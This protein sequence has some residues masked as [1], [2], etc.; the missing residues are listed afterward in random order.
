MI[1]LLETE[2]EIA[3]INNYQ[4]MHLVVLC[5]FQD[6]C[7]SRKD[8]PKSPQK[9]LVLEK[10]LTHDCYHITAFDQSNCK[11]AGPALILIEHHLIK[12]IIA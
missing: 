6:L 9:V 7:Q 11:K 10:G 5:A 2:V 3:K 12:H 1:E 4:G 8:V